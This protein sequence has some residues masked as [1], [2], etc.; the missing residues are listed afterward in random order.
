[1]P[2]DGVRTFLPLLRLAAQQP[3]ITRPARCFKYTLQVH[4]FDAGTICGGDLGMTQ[5]E[6][7][8]NIAVVGA[9]AVGGYFGGLLARAGAPVTMIGRPTF[10]DAVNKNGLFLDTLQFQDNI[11]VQASTEIS[12]AA[13]AEIILFCVKTT[14]N[15][16]TA[17]QLA[18]LLTPSALVVSLQNGVDNVEQIRAAANLEVLPA[19]VYVAASVPEPGRIKHVGRGD[20]TLGPKTEKTEHLAAIFTRAGIPCRISDN[21]GGELWT[22]LLWNCALNAISALGRVKY[23]QIAA[24]DD[25]RQVVKSLVEEVFAVATAAGIRLVGVEDA[26]AAF[27]G[28]IKVATQMSG[29]LSSTAQDMLRGK[30]TEI[31][32]L[33]GYISR[34][35][36]ELVVPTPVNHA[37]YTMIRLLEGR[38]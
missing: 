9:G 34:R 23:G 16:A 13:G 25:A 22:K 8:P 24:S 37:L 19:V 10:V 32:S 26:S 17:G 3:A 20:L 7:W 35:G 18:P 30:H 31:D 29:A 2:Q 1:M 4:R 11:R 33:N 36:A 15:A 14:D 38:A 28:A 21:I 27:A 6:N 5:T 12:A